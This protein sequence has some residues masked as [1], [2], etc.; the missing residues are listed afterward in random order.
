MLRNSVNSDGSGGA[1]SLIDSR[2][3]GFTVTVHRNVFYSSSLPVFITTHSPGAREFSV[4]RAPHRFSPVLWTPKLRFAE[5][6]HIRIAIKKKFIETGMKSRNR[7]I[8]NPLC[9]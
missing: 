1:T 9:V 7:C 4:L 3:G 6:F 8:T 2:Q 5:K